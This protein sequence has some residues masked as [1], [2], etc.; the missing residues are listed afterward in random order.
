[1]TM[2]LDFY[3]LA[4]RPFSATPDPKFLYLTPRHQE[5]LAQLRYGVHENQGLV[6]LTG[7]IGTGKTTLLRALCEGLGE[8]VAVA[9][10]SNCTL[11]FE[12][13]LDY[14]LSQFGISVSGASEA[15]RFI[16]LNKLLLER[17]Q[18]GKKTV[19]ILDE[20]QHLSVAALEKI[21]LLSNFET[22]N[23]KLLHIVLVGQPELRNR[24][25]AEELRS[26]RQRIAL[27][28]S[29]EPLQRPQ[30][31]D[32]IRARLRIAGARDHGVF[33]DNA[34]AK[35]AHYSRGVPRVINTL[36]HHCLLIG[37]ADQ[38][39]RIVPEIVEEA[40]GH[41]VDTVPLGRQPHGKTSR[42]GR[43]AV[44]TLLAACVAGLAILALRPESA[45]LI[46]A[47]RSA[48]ELLIR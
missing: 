1:M 41:L 10:I 28:F 19:L 36:C 17:H 39:R 22:S 2:Y 24:L 9:F 42:L 6:V 15:E 26:L 20:A 31:R 4:E 29:I 47:A 8:D 5:A 7:A 12:G 44:G 23:A 33:T 38:K 21:R 18:A 13:L 40:R 16:A 46:E 35:I 37:Y 11:T 30:V 32:Y 48:G 45:Q 14:M 27:S 3:G 25:A 43:W 34:V